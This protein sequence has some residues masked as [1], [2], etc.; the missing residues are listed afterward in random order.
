[1]SRDTVSLTYEE[2]AARLGIDIQSARRRALRAKWPKSR[3]NDKRARVHVP[4]TVLP[5]AGATVPP[6]NAT[7][8]P[9]VAVTPE[10]LSLL[11]SQ[12]GEL[13]DL[14][15]RLGHAEGRAERAEAQVV[16][17]RDRADAE[18]AARQAAE[19]GQDAARAAAEAAR[20]GREAAER[21]LATWTAGGP[22]A[23]AWRAFWR[24]RL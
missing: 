4:A 20:D 2:L 3:G 17:E 5:A 13:A 10:A 11:V 15:H 6:T 7:S 9:P 23:R 1:M 8:M 16:H 19:Q 22:L 12:V 14:R 18:R 24:G 21:E